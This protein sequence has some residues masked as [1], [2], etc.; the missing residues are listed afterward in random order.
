MI[1]GAK[2]RR[3]SVSCFSNWCKLSK[4]NAQTFASV[5]IFLYLSFA[6]IFVFLS[7]SYL[8]MNIEN[9]R[10]DVNALKIRRLCF[11][12]SKAFF[13]ISIVVRL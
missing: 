11:C 8:F 12:P 7:D 9:M 4:R 2:L 10:H 1:T 5:T 3:K 6:E 13:E